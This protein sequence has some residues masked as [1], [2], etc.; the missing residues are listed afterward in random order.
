MIVARIM[1]GGAAD[2]S[3]KMLFIFQKL[4]YLITTITISV[5]PA[6]EQEDVI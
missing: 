4:V 2:R 5:V 1:R 6:Y 3:G